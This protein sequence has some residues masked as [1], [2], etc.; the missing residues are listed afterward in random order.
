MCRTSR[1][2]RI[3]GWSID[4]RQARPPDHQRPRHG[5]PQPSANGG[6][7][8]AAD[9]VVQFTSR[10]VI[11]GPTPLA[12]RHASSLSRGIGIPPARGVSGARAGDSRAR[13][14]RTTRDEKHLMKSKALSRGEAAA[15]PP[16]WAL[17][18]AYAVPL[19]VLPSAVW[20]LTVP[21]WY[22][23]FLSALSM[24][25]ALLTL[26]LVHRW[27]QQVPPWAPWVGGRPISP[28]P[29]VRVALIGGWL[30]VALCLYPF[31][32]RAFDLLSPGDV[33]VGV[34][35]DEP[36]HDPPGWDVIRYYVPLFAWGPLVIAVATDYRRRVRPVPGT[37]R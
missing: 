1:A 26:G 19:C 18:A 4:A 21:G 14:N 31:V 36:P 7:D 28:R 27:G 2:R 15:P 6:R 11:R 22:P 24:G 37:S 25:L 10:V 35:A 3:V 12:S 20:R 34:G 5:H 32:V 17:C 16:R 30:L 33:W 9:H 8:R 13:P 23:A 29:V